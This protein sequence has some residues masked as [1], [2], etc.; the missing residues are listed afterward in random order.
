MVTNYS[1][2]IPEAMIRDRARRT[3][4]YNVKE[5]S[6]EEIKEIWVNERPDEGTEPDESFINSHKYSYNS[7]SLGGGRWNYTGIVEAIV[8][9]KYSA[10]NME[11]ITNNMNAITSEFFNVL[12]T[13]GIVAAIKYLVDSRN[14]EDSTAFK[15]MQEWRKM[16]KTVARS[17]FN[18]K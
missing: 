6:E 17:I 5:L 15:E 2:V 3:L 13:E 8:R 7:V 10:D 16:A 12:V 18:L 4:N 9:D 1:A 14:D 11:A